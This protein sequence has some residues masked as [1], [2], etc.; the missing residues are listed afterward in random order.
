MAKEPIEIIKQIEQEFPVWTIEWDNLK[1]WPIL[2]IFITAQLLN[3]SEEITASNSKAS[4]NIFKQLKHSLVARYNYFKTSKNIK[5]SISSDSKGSVNRPY[6]AFNSIS[7]PFPIYKEKGIAKFTESLGILVEE[8]IFNLFIDKLPNQKDSL[9]NPHLSILLDDYRLYLEKY[10]FL[11]AAKAPWSKSEKEIKQISSFKIYLSD[12]LKIELKNIDKLHYALSTNYKAI[13]E[14][15]LQ[16]IKKYKVKTVLITCYYTLNSFAII[17]ACKAMQVK[18]VE[19]QHGKQGLNHYMYSSWKVDT[20]FDS[21][22]FPSL[23]WTWGK[24]SEKIISEWTNKT[25]LTTFVGGNPW[26]ALNKHHPAAVDNLNIELNG[27]KHIV[28]FTMQPVDKQIMIPDFLIDAVKIIPST[29]WLFRLHP[30]MDLKKTTIFIEEKLGKASMSKI[31]IEQATSIPL[32][33]LLPH[34]TATI[35]LWSSVAV[36][37]LFYD[38]PAY[39]ISKKG[40]GLFENLIQQQF[41]KYVESADELERALNQPYKIPTDKLAN[42]IVV[43]PKQIEQSFKKYCA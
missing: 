19:V 16:F 36:E 9:A 7:D 21:K 14:S 24:E 33:S 18:T 6:I 22:L 3:D 23:F 15:M 29:K 28:L 12:S 26:L 27:Y 10:K 1:I 34:I 17:E 41:I 42:M 30:A 37:A 39:I 31:D 4:E 20:D 38:K 35:T 13:Y 32:Y 43:E 2:R 5:S 8:D 40:E 25:N 11:F